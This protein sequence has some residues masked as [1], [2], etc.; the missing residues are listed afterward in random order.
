MEAIGQLTAFPG[1]A[2]AFHIT[3]LEWM[4]LP[5]DYSLFRHSIAFI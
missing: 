3:F 1:A 5:K 2:G 4:W